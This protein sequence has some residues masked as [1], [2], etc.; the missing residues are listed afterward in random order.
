MTVINKNDNKKYHVYDIVYDKTGYP[1]FLIYKDGQWLRKSAKHFRP[2]NAEDFI[3]E[4]EEYGN[5]G[6]LKLF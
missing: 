6:S 5:T 2:Y 3:K 4:M 1:Q